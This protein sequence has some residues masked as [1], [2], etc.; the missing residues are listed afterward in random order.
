MRT[1]EKIRFFPLKKKTTCTELVTTVEH[2]IDKISKENDPTSAKIP[3]DFDN[4]VTNV[5]LS[6]IK[7]K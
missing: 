1:Q 5:S 2:G 7:F 4:F 6:W 3:A